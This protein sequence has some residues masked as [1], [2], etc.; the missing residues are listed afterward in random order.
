[1]ENK[2]KRRGKKPGVR[3]VWLP[4][5]EDGAPAASADNELQAPSAGKPT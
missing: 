1:M 5:C 3:S 4:L 2:E